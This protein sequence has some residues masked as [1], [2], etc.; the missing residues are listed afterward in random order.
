MV[1][2]ACP[3]CGGI[4]PLHEGRP[5]VSASGAIELWHPSCWAVRHA[6]GVEEVTVIAPQPARTF[7]FASVAAVVGVAAVAVASYALRLKLPPASLATININSGETVALGAKMSEQEIAPPV[8]DPRLQYPV[9]EL[10]G[11]AMDEMY[12]SLLD[13]I[14][15]VVD[16]DSALPEQMGGRF[17]AERHGVERAECGNGHCGIDLL[18]PIGR[19]IVAVADGV[20]VRVEHSELGRD[21]RSG[22]YVR[23]QHADG[24]LTAYMHLNTIVDGLG[25]GDH[26]DG[27]QQIGTL[28]ATA[29][30][31]AAPHCHFSLELPNV[32]GEINGDSTSTHYVDP[33]PFLVRANI[34]HV[35]DRRHAQKPAL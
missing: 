12:P 2:A 10:D 25:V 29:I 6:R 31:T 35:A 27:G 20:V 18:G 28:G 30:F 3:R 23:I 33:A 9:P 32:Y 24:S 8:L 1:A 15:P 4:V 7:P 34:A 26:V 22:R 17:G 14:H 16:T 5:F 11:I 13:W 21:G 19:P